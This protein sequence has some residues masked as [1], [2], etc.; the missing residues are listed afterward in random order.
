MKYLGE[1]GFAG[2]RGVELHGRTGF[3]PLYGQRIE[4]VVSLDHRRDGGFVG[5]DRAGE[6]P[7]G[8]GVAAHDGDVTRAGPRSIGRM[9]EGAPLRSCTVPTVE[10]R[11]GPLAGEAGPAA[12]CMTE[13]GRRL[14]LVRGGEGDRRGTRLGLGVHV[15]RDADLLDVRA[16]RARCERHVVQVGDFH[17]FVAARA[18]GPVVV[19]GR[20]AYDGGVGSQGV[21][22]DRSG[23]D[24][25]SRFGGSVDPAG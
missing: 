13:N 4:P 23:S 19:G 11:E 24:A 16:F 2:H 20:E 8:I 5:A 17:P 18:Y 25:E 15:G 22:F 10:A 12:S 9:F 6:L 21:Q 3:E 7:S 1:L 14:R